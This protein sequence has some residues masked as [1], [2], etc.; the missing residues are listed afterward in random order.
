MA[1]VV[2][3][4]RDPQ[5]EF[6]SEVTTITEAALR[7]EGQTSVLLLSLL[8]LLQMSGFSRAEAL[9]WISDTTDEETYRMAGAL[10]DRLK[11]QGYA[12]AEG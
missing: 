11:E 8:S 3:F 4:P 2:N 9:G 12:A 5:N 6:L 10:S 7:T 1:N